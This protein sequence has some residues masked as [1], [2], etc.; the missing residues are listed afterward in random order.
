MWRT[1]QRRS[2]KLTSYGSPRNLINLV[3][4]PA[5]RRHYSVAKA[6]AFFSMLFQSSTSMNSARKVFPPTA[7]CKAVDG[8]WVINVFKHSRPSSSLGF[9][10]F[11][12]RTS[13]CALL[14]ENFVPRRTIRQVPYRV[15]PAAPWA[16][17]SR[18]GKTW[19]APYRGKTPRRRVGVQVAPGRLLTLVHRASA[20]LRACQFTGGRTGAS[21][22]SPD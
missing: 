13:C 3:R 19:Q 15:R 22:V 17:C 11:F 7:S 5:R 4:V 6:Y 21:S 2:I 18:D 16:C 10:V 1:V 9:V 20:P 12:T 8:N 14:V